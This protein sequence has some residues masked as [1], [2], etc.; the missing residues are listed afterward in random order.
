MFTTEISESSAYLFK[1]YI[2]LPKTNE[3]SQFHDLRERRT[4]ESTFIFGS[5]SSKTV[6]TCNPLFFA[7][8]VWGN[9]KRRSTKQREA[10][11]CYFVNGCASLDPIQ[12]DGA[13]ISMQA[14]DEISLRVPFFVML[15]EV[16]LL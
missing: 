16:R 9:P 11:E 2:V 13:R 10:N 3:L 1:Y 14:I 6:S 4:G 15:F 12:S 7:A 5:T 8:T